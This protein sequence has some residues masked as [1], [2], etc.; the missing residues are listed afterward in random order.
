MSAQINEVID[1]LALKLGV[2]AT[3]VFGIFEA[4][5]TA[6]IVKS[7]FSIFMCLCILCI[8]WVYVWKVF[9]VKDKD[10]NS[11]FQNCEQNDDDDL[12]IFLF[13]LA[14]GA[15]ILAVIMVFSVI[16]NVNHII[17]YAM[18]P[19]YW[20]LKQILDLIT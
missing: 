5:A 19:R 4:Q 9:I 16:C 10:G 11:M 12:C 1:N 7:S 18:N 15:A 3:E 6:E 14:A 20:A 13:G 2:A 17:Q 8:C